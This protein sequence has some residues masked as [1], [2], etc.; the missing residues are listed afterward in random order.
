ME[1]LRVAHQL[2]DAHPLRQ[3]AF[4]GE[5]ADAAQDADRVAHRVEA[6]D[7][8]RAGGGAQQAE[9]VLEQRRLAGAV[10]ADEAVDL[11]RGGVEGHA[12]ERALTAEGSREAGDVETICPITISLRPYAWRMRL[13]DQGASTL[14]VSGSSAGDSTQ[15]AS[16][17][18]IPA[19]DTPAARSIVSHAAPNAADTTTAPHA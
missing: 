19:N 11:P 10:G 6:E 15:M 14:A 12:L 1:G 17:A 18:G 9:Q 5:V 13:S 8:H 3:L 16:V 4:L 2:V 7:A